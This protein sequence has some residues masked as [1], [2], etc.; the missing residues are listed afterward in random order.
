MECSKDNVRNG[1]YQFVKPGCDYKPIVHVMEI[2]GQRVVSFINKD[3]PTPLKDIPAEARFVQSPIV[4]N[5]DVSPEEIVGREAELTAYLL[6]TLSEDKNLRTTRGDTQLCVSRLASNGKRL[7]F[8]L[9]V[10]LESIEDTP[11]ET[12]YE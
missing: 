2:G 4:S 7:Y 3:F 9:N 12:E 1:F 11:G 8:I 10:A 5:L 6:E